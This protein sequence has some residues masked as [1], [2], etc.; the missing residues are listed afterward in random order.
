MTSKTRMRK[1]MNREIPDRVPVMCQLSIGH[2]L[3]NTQISP[4][5]LWFTSEGFAEALFCL[6]ER[7]G[8]DGI[9]INL[10]G[11]DPGWMKNVTRIETKQDG[12]EIVFWRNGDISEC[13]NNDLVQHYPKN[14][15]CIPTLEEVNPD[16][17]FYDDPHAEGSLKYP[18]YY[19]I[20]PYEPDKSS[21]FP[22]YISRTIDIAVKEAGDSISVH[23]EVFSPFTQF[24]ELFGYATALIHLVDNPDKCKAILEA[25]TEGT[26]CYGRIQAKS[27]VDAIVISSAFAGRGFISPV[28]YREFVQPYEKKVVAA[29][30]ETGVFVYIHTCGSIGDR[31]ELIMETGVD[32]IEC[33]DPPP[34]GDI[35]LVDAK[36]RM[37]GKAFIKGNIDPVNTLLLKSVIEVK[38]DVLNR[39]RIGAP[40]GGYILSSACS[41]APRVPPE[42]IKI[43]AESVKENGCV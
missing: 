40:G 15:R 43:L 19:G 30:K 13:P 35:D 21:Y 27:G 17:L 28:F 2:Y 37:E 34:I 29:L 6:R 5:R 12:G 32:G 22:D 38:R 39:L 4:S 3:L 36:T 23:G 25:Y 33:L 26:I 8:F 20:V 14:G 16:R 9:L 1:A 24:M 18:F 7:Y 31:L 10:P 41:V 11:R 42:N